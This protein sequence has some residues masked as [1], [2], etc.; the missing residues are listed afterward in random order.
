MRKELIVLLVLLLSCAVA[1][2]VDRPTEAY[3]SFFMRP[4]S[5]GVGARAIGMGGAFCA[6]ADD[7]SATY[8]NPAGL[9]QVPYWAISVTESP[10]YFKDDYGKPWIGS[11]H[12][13]VPLAANFNLGL[14][15]QRLYHPMENF[16]YDVDGMNWD[17]IR[18]I[19]DSNRILSSS[20][21]SQ[22][23]VGSFASRVTAARDLSVGVNVKWIKNDPYY[24]V[25]NG[26]DPLLAARLGNP[27]NISGW[28]V[29]IGILSRIKLAKYGREFRIGFRMRDVISRVKYND[30][31]FFVDDAD[32]DDYL[33]YID[34]KDDTPPYVLPKDR[35]PKPERVTE[36]SRGT[37]IDAPQV[38]TYSLAYRHDYLLRLDQIIAVDLDQISDPRVSATKN[39][40]IHLGM[41]FWGFQHK[42]GVRG[43]Y[44]SNFYEAGRVSVGGS[45]RDPEWRFQLDAALVLYT[46]M[47]AGVFRDSQEKFWITLGYHWGREEELPPPR[48]SAVVSPDRFAPAQDENAHFRV[49]SSTD[50]GISSWELNVYDHDNTLVRRFEGGDRLP[51]RIIWRGEDQ[52]HRPLPDGDYTFSFQVTDNL[53][54]ISATRN[55]VIGIYTP[56]EKRP[57]RY[58]D[59]SKLYDV[60]DEQDAQEARRQQEFSQLAKQRMQELL[61]A[62]QETVPEAPLEATEAVAGAETVDAAGSST[63]AYGSF[64]G[65][66]NIS[67]DNFLNAAFSE[68]DQ[69]AKTFR[70]SY[71][72][73]L[74]T[75]EHVLNKAVNIMD[76]SIS[77]VG[78]AMDYVQVDSYFGDN[79]LLTIRSHKDYYVRHMNGTID[80][81]QFLDNSQVELNGKLIK[82]RLR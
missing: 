13:N 61:A 42:M 66:P 82:P 55:Q 39:K 3:D 76:Q 52:F 49:Y 59:A 14:S 21:Q 11:L 18:Q 56:E 47:V 78:D 15:W 2:A 23:F 27:I 71:K 77:K 26:V 62:N 17:H 65:F 33:G 8:W 34:D 44:E 48:V 32:Y 9:I 67:Q 31:Y 79:S 64:S 53:N 37:E 60:L 45:Y 22:Q 40:I 4:G 35:R 68:D 80:R 7:C 69:G 36:I 24:I 54:H 1:P 12:A 16:Y 43:G 28:G 58:A 81:Q 72:T 38:V 50:T 19:P 51:Q 74:D 73:A 30:D 29:D 70:V 46:K 25:Y 6:V 41:E 63:A 10:V 75:L 20:L 5:Y 57:L